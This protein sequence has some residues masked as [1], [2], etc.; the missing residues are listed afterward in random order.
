MLHGAVL[1][2]VLILLIECVTVET[3]NNHQT[4]IRPVVPR[5]F[6]ACHNYQ[7]SRG[8]DDLCRL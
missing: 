1:L 2:T 6:S 4:M 8:H 3:T 5:Q 7:L